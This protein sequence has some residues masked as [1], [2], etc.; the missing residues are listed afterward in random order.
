MSKL[1]W[2]A[3]CG[4]AFA[5][6]A[7]ENRSASASGATTAP[8]GTNEQMRGSKDVAP[9]DEGDRQRPQGSPAPRS[10]Y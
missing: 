2:I 8:S 9:G 1:I 5:G 10:T 3:L 7:S 4:L 6:C